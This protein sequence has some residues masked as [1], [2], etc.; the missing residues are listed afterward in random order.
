[1]ST[2]GSLTPQLIVGAPP[3][4][5]WHFWEEGGTYD[6]HEN[7]GTWNKAFSHF[8]AHFLVSNRKKAIFTEAD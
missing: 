6:F 4:S 5:C 7:L 3:P 8:C 1:M 2:S